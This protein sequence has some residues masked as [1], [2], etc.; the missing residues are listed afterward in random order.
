MQVMA[1]GPTQSTLCG[2]EKQNEA[3][4]AEAILYLR[5]YLWP[6]KDHLPTSDAKLWEMLE[7]RT[8]EYFQAVEIRECTISEGKEHKK[9]FLTENRERSNYVALDYTQRLGAIENENGEV[10]G[11]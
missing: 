1:N 11:I 3:Y 5:S 6:V 10:N 9:H 4:Y 8:A 7:G 2:L